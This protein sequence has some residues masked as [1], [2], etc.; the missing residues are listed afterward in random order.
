MPVPIVS[1]TWA[2][3]APRANFPPT[4]SRGF[5]FSAAAAGPSPRPFCPWHVAHLVSYDALPFARVSGVFL[6][7]WTATANSMERTSFLTVCIPPS[8]EAQALRRGAHRLRRALGEIDGP[9][10]AEVL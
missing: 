8:L 3:F 10:L 7:A 6:G 1:N 4:R 5:G 2:G 9:V